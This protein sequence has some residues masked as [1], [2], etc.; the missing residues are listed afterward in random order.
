MVLTAA[1][2]MAAAM[3]W[4]D[5]PTTPEAKPE[6]VEQ[7][8]QAQQ[9]QAAEQPT[10]TATEEAPAAEAEA[11]EDKPFKIPAGYRARTVGGKTMYCTKNVVLG[12]RFG[13]ESCRTEAQLRELEAQQAPVPANPSCSGVCSSK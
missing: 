8:T 12:T 3:A 6:A 7:A 5:E 13:K 4:A 1:L 2:M 11:E 9:A 10:A